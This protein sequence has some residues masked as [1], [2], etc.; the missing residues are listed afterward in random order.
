[1]F[2]LSR[3]PFYYS[4]KE[5]IAHLCLACHAGSNYLVPGLAGTECRDITILHRD[6]I[7]GPLLLDD[8]LVD[9]RGTDVDHYRQCVIRF[10]NDTN[11]SGRFVVGDEAYAV[12][13]SYFIDLLQNLTGGGCSKVDENNLLSHLIHWQDKD[14]WVFLRPKG[15]RG[16]HRGFKEHNSTST[17][18]F[19]Y[20]GY[21]IFFLSRS[22]K[23][24]Q[25]MEY[26][27]KQSFLTEL[28]I[29]RFPSRT[30]LAR[31]AMDNYVQR[32]TGRVPRRV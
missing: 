2:F 6:A 23:S 12:S 1:M 8:I 19:I 15:C 27:R 13:A 31:Q 26:C 28:W 3:M 10:L 5:Y 11:R 20:L 14:A 21:V 24:E 29:S 25:L 17:H 32:V 30:K 16:K 18:Y 4:R 7:H 22:T 9:Y